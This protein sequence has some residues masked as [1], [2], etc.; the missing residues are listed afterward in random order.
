MSLL[1]VAPRRAL[2][3]CTVVALCCFVS[4]ALAFDGGPQSKKGKTKPEIFHAKAKIARA[5]VA[6]GDAAVTIRIDQYTPESDLKAMEQALQSGGSA[7]FVEALRKA[8]VAGQFTVGEQTFTI[9]WARQKPTA[10]GRVISVVI[11]KPVFFVGAGA[12]GAKP[13]TGYD[14]AVLQ[15]QMDSANIGEG[16]MA[17]AARVKPGGATG[18]EIDDYAE[19]PLKLVSVMK[20]IS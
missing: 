18:V 7:A 19:A 1:P 6:A 8:P 16:T 11:D 20:V 5:G 3:L 4:A 9:R 2:V 17:A 15:L 12:P 14:V 10:S 13:R